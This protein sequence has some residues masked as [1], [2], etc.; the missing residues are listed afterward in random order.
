[1]ESPIVALPTSP[2]VNDKPPAECCGFARDF[3]KH[4]TYSRS[5]AFAARGRWDGFRPCNGK[6]TGL[7]AVG[8]AYLTFEKSAG[9]RISLPSCRLT[10]NADWALG[11]KLSYAKTAVNRDR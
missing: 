6:G 1:V 7:R 3:L 8:R 9:M 4:E 5:G 11:S 10:T 2:Y